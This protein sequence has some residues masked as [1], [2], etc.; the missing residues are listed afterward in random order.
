MTIISQH[1]SR[2]RKQWRPLCA[3][4]VS[5]GWHRKTKS[6]PVSAVE[7]NEMQWDSIVFFLYPLCIDAQCVLVYVN[8]NTLHCV[9]IRSEYTKYQ[10]SQI[11]NVHSFKSWCGVDD[12]QKMVFWSLEYRWRVHMWIRFFDSTIIRTLCVSIYFTCNSKLTQSRSTQRIHSNTHTKHR[13][14][15]NIARINFSLL[16][17]FCVG[18]GARHGAA[19]R[20]ME[21]RLKINAIICSL[22]FR[23]RRA[24]FSFSFSFSFWSFFHFYSSR[25]EDWWWMMLTRLKNQDKVVWA[26]RDRLLKCSDHFRG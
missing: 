7:W 3:Y 23:C 6:A 2:Q 20:H 25:D 11:F 5:I 8:R 14:S 12:W 16:E 1:S 19:R 21:F 24:F 9:Q 10:F 15:R 18:R 26:Y 22:A 17:K 4:F 13:E